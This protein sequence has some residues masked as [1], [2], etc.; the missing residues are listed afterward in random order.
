MRARIN[1]DAGLMSPGV[2]CDPHFGE[3][4][5]NNATGIVMTTP[6]AGVIAN[7]ATGNSDAVRL[8]A[9]QSFGLTMSATTGLITA[10]RAGLYFV[11]LDLSG[12]TVVNTQTLV[13]EVFK[14]GATIGATNALKSGVLTQA[15]ALTNGATI[16][17]HGV[18][19]LAVGST[20]S[21]VITAGVTGDFTC[22]NM[23]FGCLQLT[24]ALVSPTT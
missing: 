24:D 14:D 16:S 15:T 23:R 18:V 20:L 1:N 12:I 17:L 7:N 21:A 2:N 6:T 9:G 4:V 8:V 11:W 10:A 3:L 22:K 13:A 19:A 5:I